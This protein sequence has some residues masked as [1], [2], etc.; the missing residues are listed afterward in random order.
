MTTITTILKTIGSHFF[1]LCYLGIFIDF[2]LAQSYLI[3]D[4]KF[5][6]NSHFAIVGGDLGWWVKIF[7]YKLRIANAIIFYG[8]VIG[9]QKKRLQNK[10]A[11]V[12]GVAYGYSIL[13]DALDWYFNS[14]QG[15]ALIDFSLVVGGLILIEFFYEVCFLTLNDLRHRLK[16]W[17]Q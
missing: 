11:L 9:R 12:I 16:E 13:K 2:I 8:A 15:T 10:E 3:W 7:T 4:G 17:N 14:N 6:T 1:K 5:S